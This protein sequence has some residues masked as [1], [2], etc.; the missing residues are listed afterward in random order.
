M[1]SKLTKFTLWF[2]VLLILIGVFCL[3]AYTTSYFDPLNLCYINIDKGLTGNRSTIKKAIVK[4]KKE[5]KVAYKTLCR[6]VSTINEDY[7]IASHPQIEKENNYQPNCYIRGSKIIHL[8]PYK[9]N[10]ESIVSLRSQM[11]KKYANYSNNFW[12]SLNK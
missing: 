10:N 5:D 7:C 9:E 8:F 4:I 1:Q 12:E 2:G 6:Y 3:F 11:I